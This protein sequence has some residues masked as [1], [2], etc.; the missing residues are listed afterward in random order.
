MSDDSKY[1]NAF[2]LIPEIGPARFK[3]ICARFKNL[4]D[5]W[6][7]DRQEFLRAGLEEKA[8]DT[9]INYR[10]KINPDAEWENLLKEKISVITI[11]DQ[12]YPKLLK[13]I[14]APPA[15]LYYR[16]NL[17]D[18]EFPLAVVGSRRVSSYGRQAVADLV[19]NLTRSGMTIVSGMALG[20]DTAAH[21]AALAA[22]GKTIAILAS[23]LD[24]S[25]PSFGSRKKLADKIISNGVIVSEFPIGMPALKQNFPIRNRII[26]GF[27]LGVLVVEAA[28]ASGAL[29]TAKYAMEHN[30]EVFAVPGSV[31]W[32]NSAG[33]NN[34][35]K[36]GAKMVV[37]FDDVLEELNLT[38]IKDYINNR[39]I[40]SSTPEEQVI[41]SVLNSEPAHLDAIAKKSGFGAAKA[42]SI[43]MLMEMKGAVK[44]LG[45]GNYTK[46]L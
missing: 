43:L 33:T 27:S 36:A 38:K 22:G 32:P 23:G 9:I 5:A 28:E 12:N 11:K 19:S 30:R 40:V 21:E 24:N 35:I 46:L 29:I 44:N 7:A 26:S 45:G 10:P 15:I 17:S 1:Y 6:K 37:R 4:S 42:A 2:N 20:V 31:Y 13:E 18:F 39:S 25:N 41:L 34:L 3:K 8:C 14:P 16:G